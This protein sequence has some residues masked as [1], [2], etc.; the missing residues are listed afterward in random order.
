[1]SSLK[2][3]AL[4]ALVLGLSACGSKFTGFPDPLFKDSN[5]NRLDANSADYTQNATL[6][7]VQTNQELKN[8][9][10]NAVS[11]RG[12]GNKSIY[13]VA[14]SFNSQ[15]FTSFQVL[16]TVV[17]AHYSDC[18]A[19]QEK[20][21]LKGSSGSQNLRLHSQVNLQMHTDYIL[22]VNF[23]HSCK[24]LEMNFDIV[25]WGGRSEE[26]PMM[27]Y[28]CE[29][30]QIGSFTF[31]PQVDGLTGISSIVGKEKFL[32][33]NTYCGEAVQ[34]KEVVCKFT[35]SAPFSVKDTSVSQVE[36]STEKDS[37][38]VSF[39]A[40]FNTAENTADVRCTKNG[41][42]TFAEKFHA[43][44]SLVRDFKTY[45]LNP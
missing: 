22:E 24:D 18:A 2:V 11:F 6:N 31:L 39:I 23:E 33:M 12:T 45:E 30:Q 25:A 38:K 35:P 41:A 37:E 29:G 15:T 10:S 7:L 3:G 9:Q 19:P 32:G 1:M 26:D 44:R 36:C 17:D 20:M 16:K 28:V 27:A 43:C 8:V 42:E 40:N 34:G 14:Y 5:G 21:T 13:K 4:F